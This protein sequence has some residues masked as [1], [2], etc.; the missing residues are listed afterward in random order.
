M[1]EIENRITEIRRRLREHEVDTL[2]IAVS[3][4]RYYLS[5]FTGEDGQFDES[6]G[7]LLINDTDLLL[8]T[9]SRYC[10]QAAREAPLFSIYCQTRG[11]AEEVPELFKRLGTRRLGFESVRMS[12]HQ[13]RR[14]HDALDAAGMQVD[15]V[16]V[17]DLVE[18]LR[19][20]KSETEIAATRE[21]L[22]LAETAFQET[23]ASV[24]P[25]MTERACAWELERRMRE[26]GADAL[27]FPVICAAGPNS[28]LPHAIPGE[29]PVREGRPLLIDWGAR[30]RHYCSDTTRTVIFGRP[31]DTF[32]RVYS[33]VRSALEKATAAIRPGASTREID[34]VARGVIDGSGIGGTY[35]HGL[36]H[37]TGLAV[38]EAPRL[39]PLKD[40]ALASGM[41][42]T[43]EPGIYLPDW[44]GVRLENQV[45]VRPDGAEV[46]TRLGFIDV[47]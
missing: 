26:L 24:A 43:V 27:S 33:T 17:A 40:S 7:V 9:D 32:R 16:P 1:S 35:G 15:L 37:G 28:A 8:V 29:T 12:V 11:L 42:V 10:V 25:G 30:F 46:L 3:E 47:D 13:H 2:M 38:H 31:D 5:G 19:V 44:G 39:S 21:A 20:I 22:R 18:T 36:G 4:N 41:L 6:A 45:V 34:A 14:I 23:V